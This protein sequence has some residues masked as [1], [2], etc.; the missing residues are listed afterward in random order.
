MGDES[1]NGKLKGSGK[2]KHALTQKAEH[3]V[4]AKHSWREKRH[5]TEWMT[6]TTWKKSRRDS[7]PFS[8]D[9]H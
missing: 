9:L 1:T 4:S 2:L 5:V 3:R 6:M 8:A 7:S